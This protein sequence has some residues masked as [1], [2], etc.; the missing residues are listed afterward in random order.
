MTAH[1]NSKGK[2]Q[3]SKLQFKIQKKGINLDSSFR[4]NDIRDWIPA[5]AGTGPDS[6]LR[7]ND[8]RGKGENLDSVFQRND[9]RERA[10]IPSSDG[11]TGVG[12]TTI[13]K[14]YII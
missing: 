8:S 12:M 4:W 6:V 2:R 13:I 7:R 9:R 11:M 14:N 3:K 1:R 5:Y 10:W